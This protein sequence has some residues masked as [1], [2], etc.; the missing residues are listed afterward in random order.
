MS[1]QHAPSRR[2]FLQTALAAGGVAAWPLLGCGPAAK[3]PTHAALGLDVSGANSLAAHAAN[4]NLLFGFAVDTAALR[5]NAAYRNTVKQQ[6]SIVV[7]ENAMKW[8]ALRPA[9]DKYSFADADALV[10]FTDENHIKLRGHTLC[11]HGGLPAWFD[12]AM[13]PDSARGQLLEHIRTVAGRYAGRMHSWD[14]VNEPIL[15]AD[16]R[17]DGL[18]TSPW[19]R[20]AGTDYI[21]AAFRAARDADPTALLTLNEFG[22]E[23]QNREDA[24]KRA[25]LLLLLRRLKQRN[26]PI[27]AVGIQS[28]LRARTLYGYGAGLQSLLRSCN[29]MD[30]QVFLTELDV[31]DRDLSQNIDARDSGVAAQYASYLQTTL[32]SPAVRAVLTWGVDD[33]HTWLN[34]A[35]PRGDKQ[36]QRSLLFDERLRPTQAFAAVRDA[37]DA[38]SSIPKH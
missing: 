21:E 34:T 8:S 35:Q 24:E 18:R 20:L 3:A 11:W 1:R 15:M 26:V 2:S 14:V 10:A 17:P 36:P 27:D 22:V 12:A 33:A 16:G 29:E 7:A 4:A 13:T 37:F 5:D 19:L 9:A 32:A 30:L 28:H 38:R 23:G 25:A 6:C 31:D